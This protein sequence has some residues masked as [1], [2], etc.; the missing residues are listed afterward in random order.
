MQNNF[1][2]ESLSDQLISAQYRDRHPHGGHHHHHHRYPRLSRCCRRRLAPHHSSRSS[3]G[4]RLRPS[5]ARSRDL[6]GRSQTTIPG[7]ISSIGSSGRCNACG[8]GNDYT[9]WMDEN[10]TLDDFGWIPYQRIYE[11]GNYE[12][13]GESMPARIDNNNNNNNS[14]NSKSNSEITDSD[15]KNKKKQK[16][17]Q[18]IEKGKTILSGDDN[19]KFPPSLDI[20]WQ[21]REAY[22]DTR[23]SYFDFL[24]TRY[25][26]F[27]IQFSVRVTFVGMLI[28]AILIAL[29]LHDPPYISVYTLSGVVLGV[30]TSVGQ[31]ASFLIQFLRAACL[32]LPLATFCIAVNLRRYLVVWLIVYLLFLF[33][34]G[35]ITANS[36]RRM[37]LMLFNIA[38]VAHLVGGNTNLISPSRL[39]IE[40]LVGALFAF[41]ATLIPYPLLSTR[42]AR[43]TNKRLFTNCAT[44]FRGLL[45]CFWASSNIQRSMGMVRIRRV[46]SSI[47][48]LLA[49]IN[50]T[51]DFTV[52]EF[53]VFDS[54]EKREVRLQKTALV[55]QLCLNL[56]SMTRVIDIVQDN[57]SIIDGS[58]RCTEFGASLSRSMEIISRAVEE[59]FHGLSNAQKWK[60]LYE[61]DPL[62]HNCA[63]T[64]KKLQ[65]E[66]ADASRVL[67]YER[68][69]SQEMEEFIPL[70]TFF[71]FSVVNFWYALDEFHRHIRLEQS[72]SARSTL[73]LLWQGLWDPIWET[74]CFL[75]RLFTKPTKPDLRVV[76]ESAKVSVAM[77]IA[78]LFFYYV[79]PQLLLLSGPS[80]IAIFSGTNPVEAVQASIMRL[81]GTLVGS[82]IGFFAA[83]LSDTVVDHIV[84]LCS[85]TA[86]LTFFR[87]G[88]KYGLLAMYANF[89][90][91]TS[92]SLVTVSTADSVIG[93]MQQNAFAIMIYCLIT[94]LVFPVSPGELLMKRRMKVLRSVS[95]IV[96]S[97]MTFYSKPTE[98]DIQKQNKS[99]NINSHPTDHCTIQVE[100]DGS[101]LNNHSHHH[102]HHLFFNN[103]SSNNSRGGSHD[104][105]LLNSRPMAF[106]S[107]PE[108]DSRIP[109]LFTEVNKLK[110]ILRSTVKIMP[111]AADERGIIPRVY[112]QKACEAINTALFRIFALVY[113]M[114]CSWKLMFEKGYFT[115]EVRRILHYISPIASDIQ[116]SLQRFVNILSFY[117]EHPNSS[118]GPELAKCLM[119][120]RA[121]I[122]E[123]AEREHHAILTVIS[124]A[125]EVQKELNN[126]A[127]EREGHD[128]NIINNININNDNNNNS[129]KNN[130]NNNNI[131]NS[132][133]VDGREGVLSPEDQEASLRTEEWRLQNNSQLAENTTQ[134]FTNTHLPHEQRA[135][136]RTSPFG[137]NLRECVG[138]QRD[139]KDERELQNIPSTIVPMRAVSEAG[140]EITLHDSDDGSNPNSSQESVHFAEGFTAPITVH[141]AEGLHTVTLS[142]EMMG[143]ELKRALLA[144]EQMVQV[145]DY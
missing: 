84:S 3:N 135:R 63:R 105:G 17:K 11:I 8:S 24:G 79:R 29:K 76:V 113:T 129:N 46:T 27:L 2:R 42:S 87:T 144:F 14:S 92:L 58:S 128:G 122:N 53:I 86:V 95:S 100:E 139:Q 18:Q 91:V 131:V 115:A 136:R 67:F 108:G 125:V 133:N 77:L 60:D 68:D 101:N 82:I 75:R 33:I 28:P 78:V 142:L 26:W 73:R 43:S 62:F 16:K 49:K 138:P 145:K 34:I 41:A 134:I 44:A 56:R 143:K 111:F 114:A 31:S 30:G 22:G 15:D 48:T 38:V 106:V 93:R 51:E 118:L 98:K 137:D 74:L 121:L 83:S 102:H 35:C 119:E 132:S 65:E 6:S 70:M 69:S 64:I 52:Y 104:F 32:W 123:F 107:A 50:Q 72:T 109:V 116:Y 21:L 112:P 39:L 71:V 88:E 127:R 19:G 7:R 10:G 59:L 13:I 120:L 54:Y 25:F 81:I 40:W 55:E 103:H 130:N 23:C 5:A 89:V 126:L 1:S 9:V 12:V 37:G 45:S 97:I 80:V 47:D 85:I 4:L 140:S 20:P 66:F 57:P 124:E 36:T 90:A 94:I 96:G 61:L 117:V 110:S 141:D 99:N